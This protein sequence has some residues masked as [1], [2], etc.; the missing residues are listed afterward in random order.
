VFVDSNN[1]PRFETLRLA[2]N[3][4]VIDDGGTIVRIEGH[5]TRSQALEIAGTL[6]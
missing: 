2:T 4:L 5:M 6:A 3:T 1:E